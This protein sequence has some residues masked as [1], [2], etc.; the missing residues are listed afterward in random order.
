MAL[1]WAFTVVLFVLAGLHFL[2]E[3]NPTGGVLLCYT[4]INQTGLFHGIPG[5]LDFV[6][7]IAGMNYAAQLQLL[8]SGQPALFQIQAQGGQ[9][10]GIA[11]E[12][13][14][15]GNSVNLNTT[16]EVLISTDGAASADVGLGFVVNASVNASQFEWA[17]TT[18]AALNVYALNNHTTALVDSGVMFLGLRFHAINS[19]TN[20]TY[21]YVEFNVSASGVFYLV[22]WAFNTK[23][24]TPVT[25]AHCSQN[26]PFPS[27]SPSSSPSPSPFASPSPAAS[28]SPAA[29]SPTPASSSSPPSSPGA[30]PPKSPSRSPWNFPHGNEAVN[31]PHPGRALAST[32]S[33]SEEMELLSPSTGM[34]VF[35]HLPKTGGTTLLTILQQNLAND[36]DP[37]NDNGLVFFGAPPTAYNLMNAIGS[38]GPAAEYVGGHL[39]YSELQSVAQHTG[40]TFRPFTI[41]REPNERL[42]SFWEFMNDMQGFVPLQ[43]FLSVMLPNSMYRS[44]AP[45]GSNLDDTEG[46]LAAIRHNLR[47]N[48][49][50]VGLTERFDETLMLLRRMDILQDIGYTKHKVLAGTR[51]TFA[52]LSPAQQE[53]IKKH[54]RIDQE[55]YEF[56]VQLFEEQIKAQDPSFVEQ[57]AVFEEEQQERARTAGACE[58]DRKEFGSW[59]CNKAE[60]RAIIQKRNV[61]MLAAEQ[62]MTDVE[63]NY[64]AMMSLFQPRYW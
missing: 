19:T 41:L 34:P 63:R 58:D 1:R 29:P 5:P 62:R 47:E 4:D 14:Y 61:D 8:A 53:M 26:T 40:T 22:R 12:N 25:T 45:F 38:K 43:R 11:E 35:L 15:V 30:S 9:G 48:F 56:G 18:N 13:I 49:A 51:A 42:V 39:G 54:N 23:P 50:L 20:Y 21:S 57:V 24:D 64:R 52:D 60:R 28:A 7:T 31:A 16:V 36:E 37:N 32:S 2:A 17:A 46:T 44:L 55:L 27:T 3:G 10:G 6:T 59:Q 33:S